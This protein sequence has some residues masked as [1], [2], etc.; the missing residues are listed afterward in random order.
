MTLKLYNTLTRKKEIFHPL[1]DG[2]V[3]MYS[4]GPTVY[5]YAHIGN[6]RTY[7]F[8]DILRR[9]ILYNKYKLNHV[10]NI[11]DVG[12]LTGD[13]DDGEDKM[14]K[15]A[16]REK[17]TVWEIADY[18]TQAFLQ[19]IKKLNIQTPEHIPKA[20]D[21][22]KEMIEIIKKIEKNGYSYQAGGNVY[23]DTS[24]FKNYSKLAKL[25]LDEMEKGARVDEDKNKKNRNDFVLWFTKSK[26]DDQEMKWDSPWGK[27]YPGWHIECTAMSTRFLG[28]QFDIHTGG[29]DHIPVHHTN[30]IAQSEAA[31]G[32]HP[33]V[34]YW[35][36]GDF[37]VVDSGKMAKSSGDFLRLQTLID[38]GYEPIVYRYFCLTAHYKQQLKFSY[39]GM[40]SAKNAYNNLKSKIIELKKDHD[41][42]EHKKLDHEYLKE[43][44]E[45]INDDLN[46][47]KALAIVYQVIKD[48][49]LSNKDKYLILLEFDK[50]LGIG[51]E[52]M[53]EEKVEIDSEIEELIKQRDEAKKNKDFK[54]SDKIR[55]ELKEKGIILLDTK[56]GTKWKK[57]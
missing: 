37:L 40:D 50:V 28:E 54:T 11:T 27:G 22:I 26:F 42:K 46:M 49:K 25:N 47:P 21:N 31:F 57:A 6:L 9:T 13:A 14:L 35:L 32:I 18:Y 10:M 12:H 24:K 5:H 56:E 2:V 15:G 1:N 41:G 44:E 39:E 17:K 43:F 55:D 36:H 33:W 51:F 4:C 53:K 45:I 7:V 23:F 8:N 52:S 34:K 38:K 20:T 30:E 19:D 16:K 29:I 48:D 3:K